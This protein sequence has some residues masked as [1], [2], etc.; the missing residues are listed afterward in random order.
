MTRALAPL[1]ILFAAA[2]FSGCN[3][4]APAAYIVAGTGKVDAQYELPDRK[5][6]VFVDDRANVIR[7][8]TFAT[9]QAIAESVTMD[10]MKEKI[11]TDTIRPADAVA[12]ARA[13]DRYENP[14]AID[15][16]GRELGAEQVIYIEMIGF[17]MSADGV[18]PRPASR[19][20]VRVIDVENRE[21]LFPADDSEP[22]RVV[23]TGIREIDP[24]SLRDRSARL[25]VAHALAEKTGDAVAKLFYE[26]EARELGGNLQP[27]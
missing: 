24:V 4:V 20:R 2:F 26:H 13:N 14:L 15:E 27:R 23:D 1:L 19:C 7:F 22:G 25:K 8:N 3:I 11:L 6:V 21:R 12:Y 9:R 5:T 18:S 16:L 10:L 17:T